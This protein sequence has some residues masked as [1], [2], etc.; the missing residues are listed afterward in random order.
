MNMKEFA[1]LIFKSMKNF[2]LPLFLIKTQKGCET[3]KM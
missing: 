3:C 1:D 2:S